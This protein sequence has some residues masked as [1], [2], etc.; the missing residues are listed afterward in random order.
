MRDLE[1]KRALVLGVANEQSLAWHIACALKREG[2][3][4]HVGYQMRFRSRVLQTVR[5]SDIQPD[6]LVRCDVTDEAELAEALAQVGAPL[7][8]LVHAVAFAPAESF[9]RPIQDND[10]AAFAE[11]TQVSA[12]S[13]LSLARHAQPWLAPEASL[14]T[15]SYLGAQRVVP[16][17]RLMGVAKAALEAGV[18]ELAAELGPRGLRVNAISAGPIRT[19]SASAV[20][21]LERMLER[22]AQVA[23]LRALVE[24]SDVADLVCFLASDK[25]RRITGQVLF[26]DSGY[27]ILAVAG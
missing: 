9:G 3:S 27:S 25:S 5:Q 23:P 15:L 2:A 10:A 20:P 1:G 7:H 17:Y 14:V 13:L 19:L 22:Y 12:W 24:P 16:G 21:D 4:V 11:A 8:A 26:V 6:G 18:R